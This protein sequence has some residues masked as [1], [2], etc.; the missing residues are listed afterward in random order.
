[1]PQGNRNT[2]IDSIYQ[3]AVEPTAWPAA[4]AAIAELV[5]ARCVNLFIPSAAPW[6]PF[7][8]VGGDSPR[9]HERLYVE[10]YG[11]IDPRLRIAA[12]HPNGAFYACH[13][14]FDEAFVAR[15]ETFQDFL[16]RYGYRYTAA[17]R[18][19]VEGGVDAYLGVVRAPAQQPFEART[20]AQ[21]RRIGTHL[22]RAVRVQMRLDA[23][24]AE[25]EGLAAA[26]DCL[27]SGVILTDGAGHVV[28]CNRF[29]ERLLQIGD[30]LT[31]AAGRLAAQAASQTEELRRLI[32]DAA[33]A[34]EA[35]IMPVHRGAPRRAL[36]L[37]VAPCVTP[38]AAR[39][40]AERASVLV[41]IGD[42]E[43][44][45][46][47]PA[48]LLARLFGLTA[49]EALLA[50][51]LAEGLTLAEIATSRGRSKNTLR[52]QT[53]KLF[54]KLGVNRQAELVRLL[55][56]LAGVGRPPKSGMSA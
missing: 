36:A 8:A 5:N 30:G 14:Y 54:A 24:R 39:V 43:T 9:E 17:S 40:G 15:D 21:L 44:R 49:R 33:S 34:G 27:D 51:E 23:A 25:A 26:L 35:D 41:F 52:V 11:R 32:H 56:G 50:G 12:L 2:L 10:H 6:R 29:A 47:P 55:S 20:L 7:S 48:E 22:S 37:I 53:Q 45:R 16:I 46:T 3:A 42:P 13:Q 1:M 31:V 28:W 4:L 38:I 19:L 18:L